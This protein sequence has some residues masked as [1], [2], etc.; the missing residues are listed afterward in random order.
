MHLSQA[1]SWPLRLPASLLPLSSLTGSTCCG[2]CSIEPGRL[3]CRLQDWA[4]LAATASWLA[5]GFRLWWGRFAAWLGGPGA[6]EDAAGWLAIGPVHQLIRAFHHIRGGEA[7]SRDTQ[8]RDELDQQLIPFRIDWAENRRRETEEAAAATE[9][10]PLWCQGL[11]GQWS[12]LLREEPLRNPSGFRLL[13]KHDLLEVILT[14]PPPLQMG[15]VA[16]R[17]GGSA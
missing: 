7:I 4:R 14:T 1:P 12:Q 8:V 11:S 13:P 3:G 17:E 6:R 15:T 9:S 10:S 2:A 16:Q 5:G